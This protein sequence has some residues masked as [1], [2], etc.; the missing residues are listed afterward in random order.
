MLKLAA[1]MGRLGTESYEQAKKM[2]P[3]SGAPEVK[4]KSEIPS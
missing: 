4:G 3:P 1:A 2:T